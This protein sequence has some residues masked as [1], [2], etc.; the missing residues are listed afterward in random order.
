[1]NALQRKQA[2][3]FY[4]R[5]IATNLI[6]AFEELARA[7]EA[8]EE[9]PATAAAYLREMVAEFKRGERE[10]AMPKEKSNVS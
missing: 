1:M 2:R 8:N 9:S 5:V 7:L 10:V 3:K 4:Q 6:P